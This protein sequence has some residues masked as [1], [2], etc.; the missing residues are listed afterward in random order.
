VLRAASQVRRV[1]ALLHCSTVSCFRWSANAA[2][3][4]HAARLLLR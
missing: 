4:L 2:E 1:A 3:M